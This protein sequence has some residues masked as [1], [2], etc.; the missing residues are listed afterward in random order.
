MRLASSIIASSDG[1]IGRNIVLNSN[2][3]LSPRII[4]PVKT[5]IEKF[6]SV[7]TIENATTARANSPSA[8]DAPIASATA[9]IAMP[10][11]S[12]KAANAAR[13]EHC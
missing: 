2:R 10:P 5:K 3:N 4:R 11:N 6:V 8:I 13:L 1:M 7:A 12:G 9:C